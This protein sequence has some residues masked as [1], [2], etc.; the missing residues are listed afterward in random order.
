MLVSLPLNI[1]TTLIVTT[2]IIIF[3]FTR[4]IMKALGTLLCRTT[5]MHYPVRYALFGKAE[6]GDPPVLGC[7][8][9]E[10]LP[11]KPINLGMGLRV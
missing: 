3:I 7:Q 4:H 9:N 11:P 8:S 1:T 10:R 2:I 6:P 5:H